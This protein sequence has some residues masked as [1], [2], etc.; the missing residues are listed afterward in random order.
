MKLIL[1]VC[2]ALLL[3]ASQARGAILWGDTY[4]GDRLPPEA[5][6]GTVIDPKEA[7]HAYAQ[8]CSAIDGILH[9]NG[10]VC[11]GE[12]VAAVNE[13]GLTV[14][15]RLKVDHGE[16]TLYLADDWGAEGIYISPTAVETCFG[17]QQAAI[18]G[19]D[20]HVYLLTARG[21]DVRVYIDGKLA[22]NGR[23]NYLGERGGEGYRRQKTILF[24]SRIYP[25]TW[26]LQLNGEQH[27]ACSGEIDYVRWT[28]REAFAPDGKAEQ[29]A[30]MPAV[31]T[32]VAVSP[33]E[34]LTQRVDASL[35]ADR[36]DVPKLGE[37]V[38][39][40]ILYEDSQVQVWRAQ[41]MHKVMQ[42]DVPVWNTLA[43][44][45]VDIS[46][47]KNEYE[48]I[49]L[50]I[51]PK[52][53][54]QKNISLECSNLVCK[55]GAIIDSTCWTYSPVGYIAN[56]PTPTMVG[57]PPKP[58]GPR[59]YWPDPLVPRHVFDAT[60]SRNY[61][62]WVTLH[63]P[64]DANSGDYQGTITIHRGN[65][66][67]IE[68]KVSVHIW[69]FAIPK[70]S[71]LT[72]IT[73][74]RPEW[75]MQDITP[76]VMKQYYEFMLAH[77]VAPMYIW[78][79][80]KVEVK[81]GNVTVNPEDNRL[82]LNMVHYCVDTLGMNKT[83]F[84]MIYR[85]GFDLGQEKNR[86]ATMTFLGVR[87]Y[88]AHG[89]Q[90]TPEYRK[91]MTSY[92]KAMAALL[93]Q[94]GLFDHMDL[95]WTMNELTTGGYSPDRYRI[96]ANFCDLIH[97]AE[98]QMKMVVSLA[99]RGNL[100]DVRLLE[101]KVN[102]WVESCPIPSVLDPRQ[103]AGDT[104]FLYENGSEILEEQLDYLRVLGWVMAK[105][106]WPG[107]FY[108]SGIIHGTLNQFWV[109]PVYWENKTDWGDWGHGCFIYPN[110]SLTGFDS[111]IRFEIQRDGYEDYEYL[112]TLRRV[113]DQM[114]ELKNK[115]GNE[116]AS[117]DVEKL[118]EA[119]EFR[120]NVMQNM[121]QE[122]Y[123]DNVGPRNTPTGVFVISKRHTVWNRDPN[124]YYQARAQTAMWIEQL[125]DVL[126]KYNSKTAAN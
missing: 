109:R 35:A 75:F 90:F 15:G 81:D 36:P 78:P 43:D 42:Y 12:P 74:F 106:D 27:D 16:M 3:A 59:G 69:A 82:W 4:S 117:G 91:V 21:E 83:Y 93:K 62:I 67:P 111:S 76:D 97:S 31:G 87:V 53:T 39:A 95:G 86:R 56:L 64:L 96:V 114:D 24:G 54:P 84:P 44:P 22:I 112:M 50:V 49:Q 125:T 108:D 41:T 11:F 123:F 33:L 1:T 29:F 48:P 85:N 19:R 77:R 71:S 107:Y 28:T 25:A 120:V 55:S 122:W 18:N 72:N 104:V 100:D 88:D 9:I 63:A 5:L 80:P 46:L 103:K 51:R 70:T 113:I 7:L 126:K 6:P 60:N 118:K 61:P 38:D 94:E 20:Y 119:S 8:K 79:G 30:S 45:H 124:A 66:T 73:E 26:A 58:L 121:V 116:M 92:V 40:P 2:I 99:S 89:E 110:E 101:G 52:G 37:K 13:T 32:P 98:P 102:V 65:A 17:H 10:Q 47:A 105:Y 57:H 34:V 115:M 68:V 23:G 14:E